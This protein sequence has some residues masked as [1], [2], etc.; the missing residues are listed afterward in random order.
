MFADDEE[1]DLTELL[2]ANY[3]YL[4]NH[5]RV[6]DILPYL[7]SRNVITETDKEEVSAKT[8]SVER[9]GKYRILR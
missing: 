9:R 5:I 2:N 4:V 6:T 1:R 3:A 8:L 7:L